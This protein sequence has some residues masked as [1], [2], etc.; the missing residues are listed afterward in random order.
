MGRERN[1]QDDVNKCFFFSEKRDGSCRIMQRI[2]VRV[3][4]LVVCVSA[5]ER[6]HD[7]ASARASEIGDVAFLTPERVD[8][9]DPS[10]LHRES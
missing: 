6:K 2:Y 8:V 1:C 9:N 10:K 3:C 4:V 5:R 7:R